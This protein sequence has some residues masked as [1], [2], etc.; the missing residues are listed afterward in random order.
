VGAEAGRGREVRSIGPRGGGNARCCHGCTL[1]AMLHGRVERAQVLAHETMQGLLFRAPTGIGM[2]GRRSCACRRLHDWELSAIGS[3]KLLVWPSSIRGPPRVLALFAATGSGVVPFGVG[4]QP[5][6]VPCAERKSHV[7]IEA[8][9]RPIVVV[10]RRVGPRRAETRADEDGLQRGRVR[11]Q[12]RVPRIFT[13]ASR[14][15]CAAPRS[16]SGR[17]ASACENLNDLKPAA[18]ANTK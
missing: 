6:T 5:A 4:G 12:P 2:P 18:L 16:Y 14:Y 3:R 17:I 13:Q 11:G 10:V 9:L 15:R 1:E 8:P 7:P